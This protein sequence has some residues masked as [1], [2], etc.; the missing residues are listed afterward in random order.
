MDHYVMDYET[1]SNCF[2]GV[3]QHYKK[4]EEHVF[5]IGKLRNDLPKFITFLETN[6]KKDQWHVSFNGLGFDSQITQYILVNKKELLTLSGEAAAKLIYAKAQEVIQR[7]NKGEFAEWSEKQLWI[8]QIDVFKLNHWDNPA[9]RSSLKWIQGSMRWAN[10]QDMPIEHTAEINTVEQLRE[11]A[12]YCRNDVASTKRIM[13]LSA[14]QIKLRATLTNTYGINLY[15]ASEPRIS[16]ELFLYF[17]E[18]K[19]GI[20]KYDLK[21]MRTHREVIAVKD[22]ILPYIQFKTPEFQALKQRFEALRLDPKNLKGQFKDHVDYRGVETHFGL[23]GVHGAKKGLYEPE[24]HM[25]IV[26]SD[27]VSYYPNLAIRNQW[28]PAHLPKQHFCDQYEWFFVER[29]K[30]P[31]S[32]PRNYVYKIIL[33]ST[34]GLSND[35][36]SYL[37]DPEFTMRIT[38][39][40]QLSLMMLYE[41]LAEEIPGAMPIMQNTDGVEFMIP[42]KYMDKYMEICKKWEDMTQLVLEHDEYQKMIV[43]DVNNYIAVLKDKE[44]DKETFFKIMQDNP[45]YL[46]RREGG[47]YYYAGTKCKGRFELDKALHKNASFMANSKA[48]YYYFVHGIDPKDSLANNK[49]IYDYCGLTRARGDWGFKEVFVENREVVEEEIQKSLRYLVT[50][51]GSKIVKYNKIDNRENMVEAGP[52]KQTIFNTYIDKPFEEYNVDID[53][54]LKK[55]KKEIKGLEP[56]KFRIQQELFN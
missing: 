15:N 5:T 43:P 52:W 14:K 16:K 50:K 46:F 11:I 41:M 36:N 33:N 21:K 45:E 7:S 49:N 51:Q 35:E 47:K 1:L 27:V 13:E 23:G 48:L 22:L 34:Y 32:D 19:T 24:E 39:N 4:D 2:L 42:K 26:T 9:K 10:V 8:K 18:K 12:K 31:K 28:A 55:I 25:T 54:H 17:L 30:I 29:K 38:I 40:G 20:K 3:F 6:R 53:F 44:V 56:E 37:Y